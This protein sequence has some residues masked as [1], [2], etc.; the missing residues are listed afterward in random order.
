[1]ISIGEFSAW[2]HR[3]SNTPCVSY[4]PANMIINA[5]KKSNEVFTISKCLH[6]SAALPHRPR[7][8][9]AGRDGTRRDGTGQPRGAAAPEPV[10]ALPGEAAAGDPGSGLQK[11]PREQPARPKSGQEKRGGCGPSINW[12]PVQ[13]PGSALRMRCGG[14]G[15]LRWLPPL[16]KNVPVS[17]VQPSGE[18]PSLPRGC[19]GESQG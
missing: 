10:P 8:G 15:T 12:Q 11:P 9:G 14:G 13:R 4:S 3:M 7:T 1:M 19:R 6:L 18:L 5:F 17:P 16:Q 2:R